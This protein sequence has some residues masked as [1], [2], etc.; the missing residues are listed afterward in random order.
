MFKE[1][2]RSRSKIITRIL[3]FDLDLIPSDLSMR[4]SCCK[5]FYGHE[6]HIFCGPVV[7]DM[8]QDNS[9]VEVVKE[10]SDIVRSLSIPHEERTE[11]GKKVG[12][13]AKLQPGRARKR[14]NAT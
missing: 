12:L 2:Q 7:A 13:F 14:I 5:P 9:W 11:I 6:V 3:I 10:Q 4:S 1:D 8:R